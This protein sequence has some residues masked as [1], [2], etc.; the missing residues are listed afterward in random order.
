MPPEHEQHNRRKEDTLQN[1]ILKLGALVGSLIVIGG[2]ALAVGDKWFV[3]RKEAEVCH[4]EI[5][6]KL[7]GQ[8]KTLAVMTEKFKNVD[9]RFSEQGRKLDQILLEVRK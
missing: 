3:P 1:K 6:N 2:A 9:D 4:A 5:N 8:D 7:A